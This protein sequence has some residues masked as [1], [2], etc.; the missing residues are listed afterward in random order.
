MINPDT[1]IKPISTL[2]A[3]YGLILTIIANFGIVSS[4]R[5]RIYNRPWFSDVRHHV[6]LRIAQVRTK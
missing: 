4:N 2:A 3:V 6:D 5:L 1:A